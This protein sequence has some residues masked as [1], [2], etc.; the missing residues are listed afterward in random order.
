MKG[1][2]SLLTLVKK[3]KG[4]L[5]KDR[6]NKNEPKPELIPPRSPAFLSPKASEWFGVLT[7]R[8][9][10][11]GIA[12]VSHTEN[13]MLA[14]IRLEEIES[15]DESI[16]GEGR[17]IYITEAR[18][19]LGQVI[20]DKDNKPVLNVRARSNPAVAERSEAM[21]HLQSLLAEFGLSPASMGKVS[22]PAAKPA[23]EWSGLANG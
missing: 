3:A 8:L 23:N 15:C 13:M 1:R 22:T 18:T 11:I 6:I 12:S 2:K 16:R 4:T 17:I 5:R 14:A 20:Y 21:R 19:Y 10:G 7:A 9:Q